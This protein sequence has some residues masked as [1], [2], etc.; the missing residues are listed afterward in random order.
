M[1]LFKAIV[2]TVRDEVLNVEI[3]AYTPKQARFLLRKKYGFSA[4]VVDVAEVEDRRQLKLP[5]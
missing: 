3:R 4:R 5:F 2:I 1:S